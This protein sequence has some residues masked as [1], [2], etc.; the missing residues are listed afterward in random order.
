MIKG[1]IMINDFENGGIRMIDI[2]LFNK[3]LKS[4]WVSG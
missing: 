2:K 4:S 3:A 1:D